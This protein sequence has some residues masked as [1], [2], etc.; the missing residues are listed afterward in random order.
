MTFLTM[1]ELRSTGHLKDVLKEKGPIVVTSNGKPAAFLVD[2]DE[3]DFEETYRELN[4]IRGLKALHHIRSA[5]LAS[6]RPDLTLEEINAEI[7]AARAER[8]CVSNE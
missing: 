1:R 6:D 4:R 3:A 7:A 5:A 2:T 8:K